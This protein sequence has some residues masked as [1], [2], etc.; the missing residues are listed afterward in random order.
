M[1]G[2]CSPL[3][4]DVHV[5]GVGVGVGIGVGVGVGV[6]VG[7]TISYISHSAATC[8]ICSPSPVFKSK[9]RV[10]QK[11]GVVALSYTLKGSSTKKISIA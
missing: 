1:W 6:V 10:Q 3:Y 4:F 2:S 9:S 11:L 7:F 8:L 5:V